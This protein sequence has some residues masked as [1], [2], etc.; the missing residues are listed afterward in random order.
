MRERDKHA[1]H[2]IRDRRVELKMTQR[3]LG[4]KLGVKQVAVSLIEHRGPKAIEHITRI[5]K[6]LRCRPAWLALG[7]LPVTNQLQQEPK[8]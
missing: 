5:A 8:A 7:E 3:E 1:G 6:A 2:R 4:E